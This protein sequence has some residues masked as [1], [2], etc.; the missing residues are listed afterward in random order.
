[1]K[2]LAKLRHRAWY[3][4]LMH[5]ISLVISDR[6]LLLAL[7]R[8]WLVLIFN[9]SMGP[10]STLIWK[11][12]QGLQ[13]M[14]LLRWDFFYYIRENCMGNNSYLWMC[15]LDP[16]FALKYLFFSHPLDLCLA[17]VNFWLLLCYSL[18]KLV[19]L[20]MQFVAGMDIILMGVDYG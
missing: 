7:R 3:N 16:L 12:R 18:K 11:S 6:V 1:L 4:G 13:A 15:T 17:N 5:F 8:F 2:I 19:M 9:C 20:K 14:L 10:L